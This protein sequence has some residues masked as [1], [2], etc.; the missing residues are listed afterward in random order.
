MAQSSNNIHKHWIEYLIK[1]Q[2]LME[3]FNAFFEDLPTT[4]KLGWVLACL[5]FVWLLESIVPL[6]DHQ[7]KKL[8]HDGINL[9]FFSFTAMINVGMGAL[10]VG[11]FVWI[12]EANIGLLN[13]IAL[14]AWIELI[15]AV[16]FLDF[17][18]QYVVHYLLHRVKWMWKFHMIH[19]SDTKVDATTGTRHHPGDYFMRELFGLGTAIAIGI[20]VA[21]FAFYRIATVFFTYVTHANFYL[22]T[23]LDK[24]LSLVFITPNVHKFH[25]HHERP[26]TDTNFGNIFSIWDRVF[27]T[28]VYDDPR[29]I[30]YGLDVLDGKDDEDIAY[31]LKVPWDKTIKT[32]Y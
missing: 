1:T 8:R 31:Q 19:H 28:F 26:W 29:K 27:G 17:V 7:Y 5:V 13:W 6:F 15:L 18:A 11:V 23:W 4:Y 16:M 12:A 22:P 30:K 2:K 9:V 3:N 14:P 20:P 25:H 21:Y 10:T 24:I 32:D